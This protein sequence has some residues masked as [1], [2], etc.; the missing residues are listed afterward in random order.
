[1]LETA[2][3][4][5]QVESTAIEGDH[6]VVG[7]NRYF[8]LLKISSAYKTLDSLSVIE[9]DYSN[10]IHPQ[11]TAIRLYIQI[12]GAIL[13]C[14][15]DPPYFCRRESFSEKTDIP[16]V[17]DGGRQFPSHPFISWRGK[18]GPIVHEKMVP[19]PD[20]LLPEPS[21]G[22]WPDPLDVNKSILKQVDLPYDERLSLSDPCKDVMLS[23]KMG[24]KT[25]I[26][27][28][29]EY[30][31]DT[32]IK[33]GQVRIDKPLQISGDKWASIGGFHII[34]P[35]QIIFQIG[36]W[37]V[38]AEEI[39]DQRKEKSSQMKDGHLWPSQCK[40]DSKYEKQNPHKMQDNGEVG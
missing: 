5:R 26:K 17:R 7:C 10:F 13:E 14:F 19:G 24:V 33:L 15:K 11:I 16:Q 28:H 18:D 32:D 6:H 40:E 2:A 34:Q 1:M 31:T 12:Y 20:A 8:K 37:A 22:L 23:G 9:T 3:N 35:P 38:P 36:Q 4:E 29:K 21:F 30:L 27:D 25:H 39:K